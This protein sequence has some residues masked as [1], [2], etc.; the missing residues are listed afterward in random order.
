MLL[1]LRSV[2]RR[3]ELPQRRALCSGD[4]TKTFKHL[5][6]GDR[7]S[8][9][10]LSDRFQELRLQLRRN[11]KGFVSFASKDRDDGTLGQGI[12]FHDNLSVYDCSSG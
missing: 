10:G 1:P 6:G 4:T 5:F 2:L 9:I 7:L 3:E 12:A 8:S 11:V